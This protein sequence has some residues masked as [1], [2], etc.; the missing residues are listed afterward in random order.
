M[1]DSA[2]NQA[3]ASELSK[4]DISK[5]V[6]PSTLAIHADDVLNSDGVTDVA[7]ALHVST[8]F[9]YTQDA[10]KLFPVYEAREVRP[11]SCSS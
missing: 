3:I 10:S 11:S 4:L 9:R 8:T 1:T 6:S 5:Q 2:P 7:P